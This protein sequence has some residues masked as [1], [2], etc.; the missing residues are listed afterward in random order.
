MSKLGYCPICLAPGK[1]RERRI[2]G[3]DICEN[4]HEYPSKS[5]L[6][7]INDQAD[8]VEDEKYMTD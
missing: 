1:L 5:V 4:G 6:M 8:C 2:D 3:N 7:K